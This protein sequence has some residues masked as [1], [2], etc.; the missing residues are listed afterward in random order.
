MQSIFNATDYAHIVERINR[1][2]PVSPA[3]WGRMR[4]EQMLAHCQKP[5]EVIFGDLK[6]KR[7]LIGMLFGGIAR[8]SLTSDKP[9]K[10]GLP[11]APKFVVKDQREFDGNFT[12]V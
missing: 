8:K 2:T 5:F 6:M 9:F 1:L 7:G 4:V 10:K 12:N 11:T 3:V